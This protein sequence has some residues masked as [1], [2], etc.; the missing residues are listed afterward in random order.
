VLTRV[1]IIINNITVSCNTVKMNSYRKNDIDYTLLS[2]F[3]QNGQ[4][5]N[6]L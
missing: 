3:R 4:A 1:E 5:K 2:L 6:P